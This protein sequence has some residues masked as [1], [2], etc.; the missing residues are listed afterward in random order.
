MKA[1]CMIHA[2]CRIEGDDLSGGVC[3]KFRRV[4]AVKIS[5]AQWVFFELKHPLCRAAGRRRNEFRQARALRCKV[6]QQFMPPDV[7]ERFVPCPVFVD[8]PGNELIYRVA[9]ACGQRARF[10]KDFQIRVEFGGAVFRRII[11]RAVRQSAIVVLL[12]A[13]QMIPARVGDATI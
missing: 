11:E 1:A 7:I 9:I 6:A 12:I 4:G 5:G 10:G 2:F 8:L 13:L 3:L